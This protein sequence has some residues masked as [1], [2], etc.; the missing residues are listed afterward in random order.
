MG[1][2]ISSNFTLFQFSSVLDLRYLRLSFAVTYVSVKCFQRQTCPLNVRLVILVQRTPGLE[3]DTTA[4]LKN[5]WRFLSISMY[6][7]LGVG[8]F[9]SEFS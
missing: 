9:A 4:L 1:F 7:S 8:R 6:G 2:S 3:R 5:G